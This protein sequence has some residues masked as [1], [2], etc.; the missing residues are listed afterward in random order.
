MLKSLME[1][2]CL[3]SPGGCNPNHIP[4]ALDHPTGLPK[5]RAPCAKPPQAPVTLKP[6]SAVERKG[7]KFWGDREG[8]L[9]TAKLLKF[10]PQCHRAINTLQAHGM[11][12]HKLT[13]KT[14]GQCQP[15]GP[16][17][18]DCCKR[19]GTHQMLNKRYM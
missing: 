1:G 14:T 9:K 17:P 18:Y 2:R 5:P 6:D 3:R 4:K 11:T 19:Y 16:Q 12:T 15:Q 8:T 7:K 10:N 13:K